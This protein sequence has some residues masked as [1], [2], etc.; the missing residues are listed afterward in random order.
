MLFK[1]G[2]L[3]GGDADVLK[4]NQK[5]ELLNLFEYTYNDEEGQD[6]EINQADKCY[7]GGAKITISKES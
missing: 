5:F 3:T 1:S 4:E 7:S 6:E 2:D